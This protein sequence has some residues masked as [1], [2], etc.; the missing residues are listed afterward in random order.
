[1]DVKLDAEFDLDVRDGDLVVGADANQATLLTLATGKGHWRMSPLI[2]VDMPAY[3]NA[4]ASEATRNAVAAIIRRQ[5]EANG[6][7]PGIISINSIW[8]VTIS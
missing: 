5:L 2:G 3:I 8:E 4:P 6:L 7:K 1:M